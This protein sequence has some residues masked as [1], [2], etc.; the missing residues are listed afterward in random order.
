MRGKERYSPQ[1]RGLHPFVYFAAA[2]FLMW[3]GG[4]LKEPLPAAG[5]LL[6]AAEEADDPNFSRTVVLV[7]RHTRQG[8]LGIVL[9]RPPVGGAAATGGPVD[10]S[11]AIFLH[12]NDA[13]I[14]GS[15]PVQGMAL[16]YVMGEAGEDIGTG[17]KPEWSLT[18]QGYAGWSAGQL[19][20]EIRR[21]RWKIIAP[22][23]GFV[24]GTPPQ[25][26]WRA[27]QALLPPATAVP[28]L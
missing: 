13:D 27:A 25:D 9:N 12:T 11:T 15:V 24:T 22:D 18:V 28:A 4:Y 3:L 14:K 1:R 7:L 21:N 8:A 2:L 16:S 26:M 17:A 6:V 10:P 19:S 23:K 5:K 20:D